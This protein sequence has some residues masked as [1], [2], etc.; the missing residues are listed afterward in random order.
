M[1][2]VPKKCPGG[3]GERESDSGVY[4]DLNGWK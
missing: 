4:G 3:E 1:L 2:L